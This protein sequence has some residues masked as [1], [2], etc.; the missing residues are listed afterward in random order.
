MPKES[1][2]K[3]K[4]HPLQMPYLP[5]SPPQA[6]VGLRAPVL[7]ATCA[8][9]AFSNHREGGECFKKCF[10]GVRYHAAFLLIVR[11]SERI[12]NIRR[13]HRHGLH[14]RQRGERPAVVRET[15]DWQQKGRIGLEGGNS[16][17]AV[18][19]AQTSHP[20]LP[21]QP[22]SSPDLELFGA[23]CD[24]YIQVH[25]SSAAQITTEW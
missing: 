2:K 11:R 23:P 15:T 24:D 8:K 9:V 5:A 18:L 16:M 19:A 14:H 21:A 12:S 25:S 13:Y 6:S 20:A 22:G 4:S 10:A 1:Q 17:P 7:P 3:K